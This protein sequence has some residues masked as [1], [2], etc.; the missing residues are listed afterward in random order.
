MN[1]TKTIAVAT[2]GFMA[3][4]GA[5]QAYAQAAIAAMNA[6]GPEQQ[7]LVERAGSWDVV[8]SFWPAAGT[9]PQIRRD[10]IAE[11]VIIG[12]FLQETLRPVSG[13]GE[14]FTRIDYLGFDRVEGRWEYM[15]LD[16]RLPV[17]LMPAWS[18]ERGNLERIE[19]QFEPLAFVGVGE[20]V[21]GQMMR[22]DMTIA[23][24]GS[25]RE[26][27]EQRFIFADGRSAPY[28]AVRYEYRR[29]R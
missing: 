28:V 17:G 10:L 19:M 7:S 9:E 16:T 25:D 5:T 23:R 18:F 13:L 12:S 20:T 21:S 15:S 8:A 26:V 24:D 6:P 1:W 14:A 22:A 4:A 11:R 27:K 2:F 29:R 3:I